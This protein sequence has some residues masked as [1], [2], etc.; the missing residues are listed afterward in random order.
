MSKISLIIG[1]EYFTRVR[2][3]SFIIMTLL[4]PI[5]LAGFLVLAIWLSVG[6]T[7]LQKVLVVDGIGLT[8][9]LFKDND[10]TLFS[11]TDKAISDEDFIKSDYD[12]ILR[13]NDKI[14]ENNKAELSYKKLPPL[15]VQNYINSELNHIME[16]YRLMKQDT[17]AELKKFIQEVYPNI[18]KPVELNVTDVE[19]KESGKDKRQ[20][21]VIGFLFAFAIYMFILLFGLQVMRGVIEEKTSRIV[22]VIISSVKPF[23]LMTGK[24]IGIAMVGLTQFLIWVVFTVI[25]V[26]LASTFIFNDMYDAAVQAQELQVAK[27]IQAADMPQ[28]MNNSS[29]EVFDLIFNRI[30][31]YLMI[32]L[33]LFYFIFGYLMYAAL[34]AAIGSAVDNETDTQQFMWP[35]TIPLI[36]AFIV[37]QLS[38]E[39]PESSTVFWTSLFPLTS[40]VVMMVRVAMG[41]APL[42]ELLL[43][44]S[45]LIAGFLCCTWLAA[46]IYRT[47]I[48]MYGKKVTYKELFKW[49]RY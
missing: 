8:D 2:K 13:I 35:V 21:T 42:W 16:S 47:G 11:Y 40:P 19:N 43:S 45:L 25:L 20:S 34:F 28:M 9:K 32:G 29:N 33:F 22:E 38:I 41:S 24:I 27:N 36:F 3:K 18:K 4:A 44:M 10:K 12:L 7:T 1:R 37:A 5:L 46:K 30:N 48:L 31:W 26:M 49:I 17:T 6:N 14:I 15:S 23:E 39:N